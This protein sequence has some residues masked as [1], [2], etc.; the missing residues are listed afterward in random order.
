M[1][2]CALGTAAMSLAPGPD[3]RGGATLHT[4]NEAGS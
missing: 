4:L 1:H 2:H 3:V